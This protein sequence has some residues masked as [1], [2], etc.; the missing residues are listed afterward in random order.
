MSTPGAHW[1]LTVKRV[2]GA[3]S[4]EVG[5]SF[6]VTGAGTVLGRSP[7]ADVQLED[8]TVSHEHVRLSIEGDAL[9]VVNLS[10]RG[11]TFLDSERLEPGARNEVSGDRAQLQLGGILLVAVR[12]EPTE[13]FDQ[14]LSLEAT[15]DPWLVVALHGTRCFLRLA[16][17]PTHV[18]PRPAA[19]IWALANTPGEVVDSQTILRAADPD[20][21]GGSLNQLMTYARQ[22]FFDAL[23]EHAVDLAHA[24]EL[25][26]SSYRA[27]ERD[28]PDV[29]DE[30]ALV[31]A[32]IEN[33]R[34]VGYQL[35]LPG[36]EVRAVKQ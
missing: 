6:G 19:A 28:M 23:A 2:S 36:A 24:A 3:V 21:V 33:R 13:D 18:S 30:R 8:R 31:R 7:A 17:R 14:L 29:S 34:G 35:N 25:V 20:Y 1:Q 5:T 26:A 11:A 27:Q 4:V 15:E 22:V 32:L 10:E 16:G 12:S 9:V